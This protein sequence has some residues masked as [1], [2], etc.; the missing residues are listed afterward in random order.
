M[1]RIGVHVLTH[2]SEDS[3]K[4]F[5]PKKNYALREVSKYEVFLVHN[6]PYLDWYM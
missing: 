4:I 5:I 1:M 3:R 6:F 2:S